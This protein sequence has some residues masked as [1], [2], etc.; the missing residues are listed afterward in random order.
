VCE[1]EFHVDQFNV[2]RPGVRENRINATRRDCIPQKVEFLKTSG[3]KEIREV[4]ETEV[5]TFESACCH[6]ACLPESQDNSGRSKPADA[7]FHA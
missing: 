5:D 7:Q 1:Q 6:A 2:K 4:H 3:G